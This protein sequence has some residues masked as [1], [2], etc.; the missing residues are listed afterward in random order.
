MS[1]ARHLSK[2]L[3]WFSRVLDTRI[4][5]YFGKECRYADV[6]DVPQ[7]SLDG[8]ASNYSRF[9]EEK[10]IDSAGRIVLLLALIPHVRP[11]L[12]DVFFTRNTHFE[13]GFTE[14]GGLK[15]DAYSGFI[16]TG[17]T[18]LFLLAGAD[19]E[20]RFQYRY[21]LEKDHFFAKENILRLK[22]ISDDE[23]PLSGALL[24]SEEYVV[25]FTTGEVRKPEF[26]A[27]FPAKRITTP[28]SW[29]DLVLPYETV[30]QI[31][32]VQAWLK[33]GKTLMND[34]ELKKRVLPGYRT[35]FYGPPGTGK[36]LTAALLGKSSG[37]DVYRVDLSLVVSK[38][39]GETEKNLAKVFDK[40][41]NRDWILFFDEADALFGKR[42]EISDAHD[43]F[44]NQEISYLLQRMED[45][46]GTVILATN[47]KSN[48]DEAFTRRFQSVIYFPLPEKE[49]RLQL[50]NNAFPGSANLDEEV[51]FGEIARK[52]ELSGGSIMNAVRY[53][54][55][56][57]LH[58]NRDKILQKDII[59]GIRKEYI[60][61]GRTL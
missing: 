23:P 9:L 14:F 26:N 35:L 17:E 30:D 1:N 34:W 4:K 58:R 49:E 10:K 12:L 6:L 25:H 11:Q 5:L 24:L 54:S 57:A 61:E 3:E 20:R 7:P 32:E 31:E 41:Q 43:R 48:L 37:I 2:E 47:F 38:Y 36:T 45:F 16:P 52:Y 27:D 46:E 13:R 50:W 21:L 40:A 42:T 22:N 18:A 44:A 51:D 19:L 53:A 33:H 29:D 60:K 59:E 8:P 39:I 56:M 28:L 15:G 55:L